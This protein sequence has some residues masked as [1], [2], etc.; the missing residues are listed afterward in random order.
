M[1][2]ISLSYGRFLPFGSQGLRTVGKSV[3]RVKVRLPVYPVTPKHHKQP[4]S[5]K[6]KWRYQIYRA[7]RKEMKDLGVTYRPQDKVE[8]Y[9]RL[10]FDGGKLRMTDVDNR[11]KDVMDAL[12]GRARGR[13]LQ[14]ILPND[15][16]VYRVTVEKTDTHPASHGR[17]HLIISR[18]R[19]PS[20]RQY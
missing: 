18:Y 16:Q 1:C 4:V 20:F 8:I 19:G 11:L 17:G 12:Q 7:L 15:S 5:P 10:Y 3:K 6:E 2:T 14:P 9:V 13:K